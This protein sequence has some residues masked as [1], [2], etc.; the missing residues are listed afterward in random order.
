[1][2]AWRTFASYSEMPNFPG[3]FATLDLDFLWVGLFGSYLFPFPG[4]PSRLELDT[5][6]MMTMNELAQNGGAYGFYDEF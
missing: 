5:S 1:M 6:M 3:L 2:T 4:R